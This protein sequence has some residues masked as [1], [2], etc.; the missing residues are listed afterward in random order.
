MVVSKKKRN[1]EKTVIF[2]TTQMGLHNLSPGM[3]PIYLTKSTSE[4]FDVYR[5]PLSGSTAII[6]HVFRTLLC[7]II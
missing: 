3:A 5:F 7:S 1:K 2:T 6:Q 4:C